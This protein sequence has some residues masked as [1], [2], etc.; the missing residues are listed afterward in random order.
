MAISGRFSQICVGF[1]HLS[2]IS[3]VFGIFDGSIP[4]FLKIVAG[5]VD[6]HVYSVVM[7]LLG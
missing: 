4:G 7:L 2:D 1:P 6:I 3:G 5:H